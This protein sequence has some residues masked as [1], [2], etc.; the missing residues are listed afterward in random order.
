MH[1]ILKYICMVLRLEGIQKGFLRSI[2]NTNHHQTA[3]T[4]WGM[5]PLSQATLR[6]RVWVRY[7]H[8]GDAYRPRMRHLHFERPDDGCQC[9]GLPDG[10]N[11]WR[12]LGH[13]RG[14]K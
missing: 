13:R 7:A 5:A 4:P 11:F 6:S 2:E 14:A 9:G 1:L 3:T 12:V 10:A 8:R